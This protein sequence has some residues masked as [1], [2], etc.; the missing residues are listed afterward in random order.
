VALQG[1]PAGA[2]TLEIKGISARGEAAS[3]RLRV[4][5]RVEAMWWR[6]PWVWLLGLAAV[7]AGFYVIHRRRLARVRHNERLRSRIAA[8]LHDE[9]GTLLTRVSMQAELLRQTQPDPS[10]ALDRLLSNS[11]AAAGTMRDIVWGIDAQ[12]D[13]VGAL[14][15]RMRDHLD[16]TAAPAGLNTH[17]ATDGLPDHLALPPE[18]RQHLYLVFKEA[19]TNAA[20]HARHATDL[21]VTLVRGNGQLRLVVHNNGQTAG[22]SRSGMGLRNMQQRATALRGKLTAGPEPEGGFRVQLVVPM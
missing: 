2:Y 18:L 14:L 17:L 22:T 21:W 6:Q 16:Q 11:R 10:P 8:D 12:A 9:V 4:P 7:A 15:D 5:L 3:N 13:T 20:R 1:L 19:V